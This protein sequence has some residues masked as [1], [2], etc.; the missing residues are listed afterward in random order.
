MPEWLE[1]FDSRYWDGR[2]P[3][4][5]PFRFFL[6]KATECWRSVSYANSLL[7]FQL[8]AAFVAGW[9][10]GAWLY[11]RGQGRPVEAA[12]FYHHF[13]VTLGLTFP[14]IVDTE[15]T[16][17]YPGR[18]LAE[19]L[20]ATV[21]EVEQRFGKAALIYS[22]RWYF[23]RWLK[24]WLPAGHPIY[25]RDLWE[26]D[27]PPD[28]AEP[29]HFHKPVGVQYKLDGSAPGWNAKIDLD[30]FERTWYSKNVRLV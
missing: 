30:R 5:A 13:T 6:G 10:A 18:L 21:Q 19:N 22:A 7:L 9:D 27:P 24:P 29:G 8:D 16:L 28:T 26:A 17:S 3:A 15:D 11:H 20:W 25:E 12:R 4:M 1:G 2:V 23:D 14:P